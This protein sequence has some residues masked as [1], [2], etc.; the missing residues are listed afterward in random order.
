MKARLLILSLVVAAILSVALVAPATA[1][2]TYD[3]EVSV[4]YPIYTFRYDG[5]VISVATFDSSTNTT[6]IHI[7]DINLTEI[8]SCNVSVS[9]PPTAHAYGD[10]LIALTAKNGDAEDIFIIDAASCS[11]KSK[12]TFNPVG[13]GY[14]QTVGL[15]IA[16]GY[17]YRLVYISGIVTH[18]L[19][20]YDASGTPVNGRDLGASVVLSDVENSGYL[21]LW[22]GTSYLN[23]TDGSAGDIVTVDT[24][25]LGLSDLS[26]ARGWYDPSENAIYI[27]FSNS[28]GTYLVKHI[29]GT[30]TEWIVTL[31]DGVPRVVWYVGPATEGVYVVTADNYGYRVIDPGIVKKEYIPPNAFGHSLG[32]E[33][34][35]SVDPDNN[36]IYRWYLETVTITE[37]T[38]VTETMTQTVTETTTQTVTEVQY[39][40][41][42]ETE[43]VTETTTVPGPYTGSDLFLVGVVSFMLALVVGYLLARRS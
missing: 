6:Y 38:T 25:E 30:G 31:E 2:W 15:V 29:L 24:V 32:S 5:G 12:H 9:G 18:F 13:G 28:T 1:E 7:Y 34:L 10:G 3:L 8:K 43:T 40:T 14:V 41:E 4:P 26:L 37:T 36:I 11:V 21:I 42:T 23:I 16:G 19:E 33:Y 20:I 27:A 22:K 39:L 17:V 35:F